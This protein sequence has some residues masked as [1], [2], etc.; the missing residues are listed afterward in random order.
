MQS[1]IIGASLD[2]HLT[3]CE[4][5][6]ME[7]FTPGVIVTHNVYTG[8]YGLDKQRVKVGGGEL[9][10]TKFHY[11]GVLWTPEKYV[12]YVDGVEDGTVTEYISGIEEFLLISTETNGYRHKDHLPTEEAIATAKTGDTF[13]VDHVRVFDIKN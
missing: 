2:P 7:S 9:D 10:K 4:V 11:F 3:G 12:F 13:M 6:I 1:P 8:G 5:D